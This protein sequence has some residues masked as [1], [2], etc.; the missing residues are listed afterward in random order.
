[1]HELAVTESVLEIAIRHAKAQNARRIT[2]LFIVVGEWSSTVDDSVQFYWDMISENTI[3]QGAKL[4]FKRIPTE[5][6]CRQCGHT[7]H[8]DS[9]NLLCPQCQSKHIKVLKG[10][11][12]YLEAIEVEAAQTEMV[13]SGVEPVETSQSF[14]GVSR[15]E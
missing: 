1:M 5:L 9:H 12:F 13:E 4:H 8:P 11:E 6:L 14:S 2:E 3:A 15:P 7:Y 10:E